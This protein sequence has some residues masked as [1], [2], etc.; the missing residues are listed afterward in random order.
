MT[1]PR[2]P[3]S[4]P[5]TPLQPTTITPSHQRSMSTLRKT[6]TLWKPVDLQCRHYRHRRLHL[7]KDLCQSH[8]FHSALEH[9]R[10][11]TWHDHVKSRPTV[12][13]S[14][15]STSLPLQALFQCRPTVRQLVPSTTTLLPLRSRR[16]PETFRTP[17]MRS[18]SS[19]STAASWT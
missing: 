18:L 11:V 5:Q 7:H 10:L 9:S 16:R 12:V 4:T 3:C 13:H 6:Q 15:S 8:H 2:H 17:H 19:R 14:H 1:I